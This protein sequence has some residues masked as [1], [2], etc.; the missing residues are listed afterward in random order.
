MPPSPRLCAVDN[1]RTPNDMPRIEI[2][3]DQILTSAV[4]IDIDAGDKV[5]VM[6]GVIIGV[7]GKQAIKPA[8]VATKPALPPPEPE[9]EILPLRDTVILQRKILES[10]RLNGPLTGRQV[11][12][13]IDGN[14]GG[15]KVGNALKSLRDRGVIR[16]TSASR[17]PAYVFAG[18][19]PS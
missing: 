4:G 2:E 12:A 9:P 17:F 10:I 13:T 1:Q 5:L 8:P 7:V 19:A 3:V 15:G 6:N 18:N 14:M 11:A 16:A